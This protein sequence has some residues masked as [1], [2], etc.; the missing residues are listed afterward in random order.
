MRSNPNKK[1]TPVK[2]EV[3]IENNKQL[4]EMIAKLDKK[5]TIK[6]DP[7]KSLFY[8]DT[9]IDGKRYHT[10]ARYVK[11]SEK[12]KHWI[13]YPKRNKKRLMNERAKF[14]KNSWNN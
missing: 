11:C 5:L 8:F 7:K 1:V 6:N 3:K 14:A 10:F 12:M 2:F 4:G 13:K 9:I